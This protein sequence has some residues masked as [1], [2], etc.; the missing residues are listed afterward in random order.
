MYNNSHLSPLRLQNTLAS[1]DKVSLFTSEFQISPTACLDIQPRPFNLSEGQPEHEPPLFYDTEGRPVFGKKAYRNT[2]RINLDIQTRGG[3]PFLTLSFNPNKFRHYFE[4]TTDTAQMRA[5][6]SSVTHDLT[7]AGI[8]LDFESMTLHRLDLMKQRQLS[9]PLSVHHSVLST[10]SA[11]RQASRAY[12]DTF[13]IGNKQHQTA[14]YDKGVEA[15][16]PNMENLIRC[17][18]RALRARSVSA[19]YGVETLSD[20]MRTDIEALTEAYNQHLRRNVFTNH[21]APKEGIASEIRIVEYYLD[22]SP[23]NGVNLYLRNRGIE[24]VFRTFGSVEALTEALVNI[25]LSRQKAHEWKRK[26]STS[27]SEHIAFARRAE[28]ETARLY[29]NLFSFAV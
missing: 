7:E 22:T 5:Q 27:Y 3:S 20:L 14:L 4:G 29:D 9:D 11:R 1:V 2:D 28:S 18:I 26:L 8:S 25:G 6:I 17:E 21:I 16:V 15:K 19:L 23:R 24:H 12:L 13:L 10:F